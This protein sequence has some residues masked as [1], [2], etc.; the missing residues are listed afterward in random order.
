MAA[1][2]NEHGTAREM[3]EEGFG[4]GAEYQRTLL[5]DHYYIDATVR[6]HALCEFG[7]GTRDPLRPQ[8]QQVTRKRGRRRKFAVVGSSAVRSR[9]TIHRLHAEGMFLRCSARC[10]RALLLPHSYHVI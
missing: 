4:P 9:I 7:A 1:C 3:R 2:A 8:A 5:V 6:Q 10:F